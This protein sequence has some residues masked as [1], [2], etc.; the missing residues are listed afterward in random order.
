[1]CVCIFFDRCNSSGH[2]TGDDP[3]RW[4][5]Q[6]VS[7]ISR[8]EP[9]RIRRCSKSHG[10]GRV[11]ITYKLNP[12]T[13]QPVKCAVFSMAVLSEWFSFHFQLSTFNLFSTSTLNFQLEWFNVALMGKARMMGKGG[14]VRRGWVL[15]VAF[16]S[17]FF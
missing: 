4:A 10:S 7:K 13:T 3:T 11:G 15:G 5:N 1:M 6:E 12:D 8:V 16:R 2:L 9:G 14:W 17:F